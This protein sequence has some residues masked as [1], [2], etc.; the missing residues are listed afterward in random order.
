MVCLCRFGEEFADQLVP[1]VC[2]C[3]RF[4]VGKTYGWDTV[5]DAGVPIGA[6]CNKR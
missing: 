2:V 1:T 5:I 4:S 6:V 3:V